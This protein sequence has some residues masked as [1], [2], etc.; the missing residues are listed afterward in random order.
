MKNL[1][2][3]ILMLF[4]LTSC[5]TGGISVGSNAKIHGN[6]GVS[7]DGLINTGVGIDF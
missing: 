4:S 5:V 7:T 2:L 1:I 6:I 3:I